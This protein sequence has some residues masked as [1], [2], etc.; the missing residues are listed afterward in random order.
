MISAS[1][2]S[3]SIA[4]LEETPSRLPMCAAMLDDSELNSDIASSA[5]HDRRRTFKSRTSSLKLKRFVAG[6]ST[7]ISSGLRDAEKK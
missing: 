4:S 7:C 2:C 5:V 3:R 6:P 1:K